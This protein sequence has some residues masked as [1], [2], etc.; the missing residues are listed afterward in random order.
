[1][2]SDRI[3]YPLRT[4]VASCWRCLLVLFGVMVVTGAGEAP[5]TAL[6]PTRLGAEQTAMLTEVIER[7]R[8]R[9]WTVSV[10]ADDG[11]PTGWHALSGG[12]HLRAMFVIPISFAKNTD[13]GTGGSYGE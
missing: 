2:T 13:D 1:M 3:F 11:I 4:W 10:I 5:T 7:M 6:D 12:I 9:L 8:L